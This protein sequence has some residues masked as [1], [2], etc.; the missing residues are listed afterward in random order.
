MAVPCKYATDF[1]RCRSIARPSYDVSNA[2]RSTRSYPLFSR[3]PQRCTQGVQTLELSS[4]KET[5]PG[6]ALC[7]PYTWWQLNH[8]G[9]HSYYKGVPMSMGQ[10]I[11][12]GGTTKP[13][14]GE[15]TPAL[16][17]M[18]AVDSNPSSSVCVLERLLNTFNVGCTRGCCRFI[19]APALG[20]NTFKAG[21]GIRYSTAWSR[22]HIVLDAS[23]PLAHCHEPP[24]LCWST[25]LTSQQVG[26]H[27][28]CEGREPIKYA[29]TLLRS[30]YKHRSLKT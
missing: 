10:R 18:S 6:G 17:F 21:G 4:S 29:A 13:P 15:V 20:K 1:H 2:S 9:L 14:A 27:E 7:A 23:E 24:R 19:Y 30:R 3:Y 25:G 16:K 22:S 8:S 28:W 5:C 12:Y 26:Y 11:Y